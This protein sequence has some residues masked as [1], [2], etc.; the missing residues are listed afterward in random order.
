[1][2]FGQT[3][4]LLVLISAAVGIGFAIGCADRK[5]WRG[6]KPP[7]DDDALFERLGTFLDGQEKRH[8]EWATAMTEWRAEPSIIAATIET[9]IKANLPGKAEFEASVAGMVRVVADTLKPQPKVP[10]KRSRRGRR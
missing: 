3:V 9:A 5:W 10:A 6:P 8:Q 7:S 1:M 4:A 2:D